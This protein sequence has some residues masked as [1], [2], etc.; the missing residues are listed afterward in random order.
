MCSSE[1]SRASRHQPEHR[2]FVAANTRSR[3]RRDFPLV[4]P[5][6]LLAVLEEAGSELE[7]RLG[8]LMDHREERLSSRAEWDRVDTEVVQPILRLG[9]EGGRHWTEE[10]VQRCIGITRINGVSCSAR[11]GAS[12]D[13]EQGEVRMLYPGMSVFSHSCRPNT[14]A[15]Q[16]I[17]QIT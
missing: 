7:D 12:Q 16:I 2:L 4:M 5:V 11:I 17:L 15:G 8:R 10:Q 13:W 6:R 14:Q 1:C 3:G 9:Q